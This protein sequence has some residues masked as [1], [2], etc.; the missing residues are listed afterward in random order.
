MDT[1]ISPSYTSAISQSMQ[2]PSISGMENNMIILEYDKESPDGLADIIDNYKLINSGNF[3]ICI[4]ASSRRPIVYKNGIHVWIKTTDAENANLMIIL[5]FILLG[6][7]DWKG[8]NIKIFHICK[9]SEIEEVRKQMTDLAEKGRLP[10]VP[11]NINII[12]EDEGMSYKSIINRE[13]ADAGFTIVGFHGDN[14][15]GLGT[16]IFEGYDDLGAILFVN[17]FKEKIID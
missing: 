4:L 16:K 14:L 9:K 6:H 15:K 11:Q 10:I 1:I 2:I 13:S 5:S 7:P 8:A 12:T 3:D 17:S